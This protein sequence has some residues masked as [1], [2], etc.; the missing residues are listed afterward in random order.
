MTNLKDALMNCWQSSVAS[1]IR[2]DA[3]KSLHSLLLLHLHTL[4]AF[5]W[6][7]Q[8]T[9]PSRIPRK[10]RQK[11]QLQRANVVSEEPSNLQ[12]FGE[13]EGE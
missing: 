8:Q 11:A 4:Y 5:V 7:P 13:H 6:G 12:D 1:L 9:E 3:E 2:R 10:P